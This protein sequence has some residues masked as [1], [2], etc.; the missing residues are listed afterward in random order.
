VQPHTSIYQTVTAG[1]ITARSLLV[2]MDKLTWKM[3]LFIPHQRSLSHSGSSCDARKELAG[4]LTWK[5]MLLTQHQRKPSFACTY[6]LPVS[7]LDAFCIML[8]A[9]LDIDLCCL[10][11]VLTP[12]SHQLWSCSG[13]QQHHPVLSLCCLLCLP[14]CSAGLPWQE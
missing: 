12:W 2:L 4:T 11:C 9:A 7:C 10:P 5:M 3:M 1:V 8:L 6:V 14:C 13:L